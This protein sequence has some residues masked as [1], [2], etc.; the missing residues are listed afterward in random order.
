MKTNGVFPSECLENDSLAPGQPPDK[1]ESPRQTSGDGVVF[2][3]LGPRRAGVRHGWS[4]HFEHSWHYPSMAAP[5]PDRPAANAPKW[6][7]GH[8]PVVFERVP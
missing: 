2:S 8:G 4:G 3:V 5:A 1:G 7:N 6:C